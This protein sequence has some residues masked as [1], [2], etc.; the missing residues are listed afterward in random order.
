MTQLFNTLPDT[1]LMTTDDVGIERRPA[2]AVAK[3]YL[4]AARFAWS[5]VTPVSVYMQGKCVSH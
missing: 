4:K 1:V 2:M 3:E 5:A